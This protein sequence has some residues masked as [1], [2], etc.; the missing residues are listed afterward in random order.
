MDIF[1]SAC[2][3]GLAITVAGWSLTSAINHLTSIV[4]WIYTE[5]KD[6]P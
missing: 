3:I 1:Y 2:I 5:D 6:T 4:E